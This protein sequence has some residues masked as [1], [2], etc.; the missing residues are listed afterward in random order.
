MN[1]S[2][3]ELDLSAYLDGELTANRAQEVRGHLET[4]PDCRERVESMRVARHAFRELAPE[5]VSSD[6]DRKVQAAVGA[7]AATS[8]VPWRRVRIPLALALSVAAT[9][10]LVFVWKSH[11]IPRSD[12]SAQMVGFDSEQLVN[13]DLPRPG[14]YVP[15][16]DPRDTDPYLSQPGMDQCREVPCDDL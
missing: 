2:R 7:P 8:V 5:R 12:P 13:M 14:A 1:C 11:E 16:L 6:F 4:C 10:A 9:M 15:C 3:F